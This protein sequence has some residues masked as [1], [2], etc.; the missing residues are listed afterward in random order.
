MGFKG[1]KYDLS[2]SGIV[3]THLVD[4]FGFEDILENLE[5]G[6]EF[7]LVLGIHLDSRHR[8]IA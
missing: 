3:T 5:V 1:V 4:F 6:Y 8:Y 7:I 2:H